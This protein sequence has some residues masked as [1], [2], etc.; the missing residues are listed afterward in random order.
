MP[1]HTYVYVARSGSIR[2]NAVDRECNNN[3]HEFDTIVSGA[4]RRGGRMAAPP[5]VTSTSA[6]RRL[7]EDIPE[8][9]VREVLGY[10]A[11]RRSAWGEVAVVTALVEC[12]HG[13]R[14]IVDRGNVGSAVR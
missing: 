14:S 12:C 5:F 11:V 9:Q 13:C 1:N 6:H 7:R 3:S 8:D 10:L 4:K 2:S